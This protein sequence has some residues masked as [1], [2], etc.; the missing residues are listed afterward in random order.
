MNNEMKLSF[1]E[2]YS[3]ANSSQ[4]Q[5]IECDSAL[6]VVAASAGT[7][8]TFTLA[9]KVAYI[10]SDKDKNVAS[11]EILVL[12]FTIKAA[13]EMQ[14]RI[15]FTLAKWYGAKFDELLNQYGEKVAKSSLAYLK[16]KLDALDDAYISNLHS[17]SKRVIAEGGLSL[18]LDPSATIIAEPQ[19]V[20]WFATLEEE[21]SRGSIDKF[22]SLLPQEPSS[23]EISRREAEEFF[24]GKEAEIREALQFY[25]VASM[26][27]TVRLVGSELPSHGFSAR[28]LWNWQDDSLVQG[29]LHANPYAACRYMKKQKLQEVLQHWQN[30]TNAYLVASGSFEAIDEKYSD[31][32]CLF[33]FARYVLTLDNLDSEE[34]LESF[35]E[36]IERLLDAR[37]GASTI[38]KT[39]PAAKLQQYL[40]Q[41]TF[42]KW[43]DNY[44]KNVKPYCDLSNLATELEQKKFLERICAVLWQSYNAFKKENNLVELSELVQNAKKLFERDEKYSK[45]FKYIFVD[46]FQDTDPLQD[47]LINALWHRPADEGDIQNHLFIVGDFKQ[48][49]YSFRGAEPSLL[50]KYKNYALKEENKNL[51]CFIAL[52]ENYR[53]DCD[54]IHNINDFFSHL[55]S[56][57]HGS[58]FIY[59]TADMLTYPTGRKTQQTSDVPCRI[60][61]SYDEAQN[62]SIAE[63]RGIRS[64]AV[65]EDII[66]RAKARGEKWSNFCVLV[67]GRSEFAHLEAS[68]NKRKIPFVL[69]EAKNFFGKIETE[70]VVNYLALLDDNNNMTALAGWLMSPISAVGV[71]KACEILEA[72]ER[73]IKEYEK[74]GSSPA[75]KSLVLRE[76][77]SKLL[78]DVAEALQSASRFAKI[79]GASAAIEK[80]LENQEQLLR[81]VSEASQKRLLLNLIHIKEIT[82]EFEECFTPSLSETVVYLEDSLNKNVSREEPDLAELGSN[83]VTV[84]TIHAS[85]GLEFDNVYLL[86]DKKE[87]ARSDTERIIVSNKFGCLASRYRLQGQETTALLRKASNMINAQEEQAEG[88]RLVYVAF[89]R[90]KKT[91]TIAVADKDYKPNDEG[92]EAATSEQNEKNTKTAPYSLADELS[93]FDTYSS[94]ERRNISAAD[95]SC[96]LAEEEE[97]GEGIG[98]DL[99]LVTKMPKRLEK[100]TASAYSLYS[101]C[102]VAYRS[103]YRQGKTLA[104]HGENGG[105]SDFGT[106]CHMVL[107]R[108]NFEPDSLS[109]LTGKFKQSGKIYSLLSDFAKTTTFDNLQKLVA[110]GKVYRE[111][112]FDVELIND[113]EKLHLV[114]VID[115]LWQDEKGLHIRDW[116]TTEEENTP[117]GFYQKQLDFYALALHEYMRSVGK[118]VAIDAALIY[119]SS[120]QEAKVS[121]YTESDF[122]TIKH[123]VVECS[124][125]GAGRVFAPQKTKCA[126]CP[127]ASSCVAKR[128]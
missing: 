31:Q 56:A 111:V 60:L 81:Y 128:M 122:E 22:I 61:W 46:E 93:V 105:G 114:G 30:A 43:K 120:E 68:F 55:W 117:N 51:A 127:M 17:F 36:E 45:K 73:R 58:E 76:V 99:D 8:K 49:I 101:W 90:A 104:W 74:T 10:L 35:E 124:I 2:Y 52:S 11:D 126:S 69:C 82:R 29:S 65:A 44:K 92:E 28:D 47:N 116:K 85:K 48:S 91:L 4:R 70:D 89:T 98:Q 95:T 33:D 110:A 96:T 102:P 119:L 1:E 59:D 27:N 113:G 106:A 23:E 125:G 83:A 71:A 64:D 54:L 18:D 80:L 12:T 38:Q 123:G 78:P 57:K 107:K 121:C 66:T 79:M 3:G 118:S 94:V 72:T 24:G 37:E 13:Q 62:A 19:S 32:I 50:I 14:E 103:S 41:N 86:L 21:L 109:L 84:M 63:L 75:K 7:G 20:R 15:K 6:T 97:Q 16:D 88:Q 87:N 115:L 77:F 100:L 112:P 40:P 42:A 9:Q 67:R 108:W 34:D 25:N 26:A 5:A 53:T 39:S